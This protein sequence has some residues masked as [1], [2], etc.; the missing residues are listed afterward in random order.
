MAHGFSSVKEQRLDA[1][2]ERFCAAGLG[3][4]VFD[5]RHFGVSGGEPRQLVDISRQL[6]DWKTAVAFARTLEGADPK[7]VALWGSSFSGGHVVATAADDAAVAAV[8]AQA[9]FTDGLSAAK[10]GG[11]KAAVR[12]TLAG[13]RDAAAA[14]RGAPP[15]TIP[16]AGKPGTL[17]AMTA[18]DAY[19]GFHAIDPPES[20]WRNEVAARVALRLLQYR[21]FAKLRAVRCPVLVCVCE[22]DWTTPPE[23]AAR[24][25]ERSP[26]TELRRYPIGHFEIYSGRGFERAVTDQTEFLVRTL[27]GAP[28]AAGV[29]QA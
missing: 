17:A 28:V 9:P 6:A 26:N 16:A 22:N 4:L 19:D 14:V 11:A 15:V 24:A 27:L 3:V 2:A 13:L 10:A 5:Y 8:V 21:P 12:L 25:A 20:A 7:R 1:Y 29:D 18:P 23:P